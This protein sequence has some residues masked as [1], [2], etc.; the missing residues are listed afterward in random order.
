MGK[1]YGPSLLDAVSSEDRARII[2]LMNSI[3]AKIANINKV[4]IT[5]EHF[6]YQIQP[7]NTQAKVIVKLKNEM[8]KLGDEMVNVAKAN[9]ISL[10]TDDV[11]D[12]EETKL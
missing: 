12:P 6:D 1:S 7:D 10:S 3:E 11:T 2:D 5:S 8:R 4:A 9:G